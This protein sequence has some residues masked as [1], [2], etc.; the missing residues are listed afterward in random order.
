MTAA[1][2]LAAGASTR[3]GSP[4]QLVEL[5]GETLVHRAA[6]LALEAS[7]APVVV[8]EGAVELRSALAGLTVELV[9]CDDWALGMGASIR[10]GMQALGDR[11]DAVVILLV[12]QF[13]L[14]ADDVRT[15]ITT[16]GSIV[17]T[18]Y[19]DG[20]GVPARF[21]G[22]SLEVLRTLAPESGARSWL[23]THRSEVTAVRLAGA[24]QDLDRPEDFF[25]QRRSL[26][27]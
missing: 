5:D 4:K 8:I 20:P 2:V 11:A 7:C 14:V 6:R 1:L 27:R 19:D 25:A 13:R 17:A 22:A 10:R 16:G 21:S 12:D 15:L 9:R 24:G 23:R 26:P 18:E 3:L